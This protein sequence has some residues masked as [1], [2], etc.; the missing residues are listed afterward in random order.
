[1]PRIL[2]RMLL[3]ELGAGDSL[4]SPCR[5]SPCLAAQFPPS[6]PCAA[7]AALALSGGALGLRRRAGG[8]YRGA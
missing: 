4:A 1:M 5:A 6:F 2:R 3:P 7:T 8:P